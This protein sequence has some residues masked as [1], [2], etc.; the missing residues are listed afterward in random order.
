MKNGSN[1]GTTEVAHKDKAFF[2]AIKLECE[3][4]T[5]QT[6]NSKNIIGKV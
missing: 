5:R 4:I 2:V 6:V 3:N 1:E